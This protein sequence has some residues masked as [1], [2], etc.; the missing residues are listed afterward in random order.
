MSTIF[1]SN[2]YDDIVCSNFLLSLIKLY[3]LSYKLIEYTFPSLVITNTL[4]YSVTLLAVT[5]VNLSAFFIPFIV[6]YK[7]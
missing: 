7:N 1:E 2:L 3:L 5:I 4:E 6:L